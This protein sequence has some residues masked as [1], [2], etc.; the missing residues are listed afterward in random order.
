LQTSGLLALPDEIL[1][2]IFRH[3]CLFS[4]TPS[5]QLPLLGICHKLAPIVVDNMQ[6]RIEIR[7]GA[8][9]TALCYRLLRDPAFAA[10]VSHLSVHIDYEPDTT[11]R[12]LTQRVWNHMRR[13]GLRCFLRISGQHTV[14]AVWPALITTLHLCRNIESLVLDPTALIRDVGEGLRFDTIALQHALASLSRLRSFDMDG[15]WIPGPV[16]LES[17]QHSRDSLHAVTLRNIPDDLEEGWSPATAG[18]LAGVEH[19]RFACQAWSERTLRMF[20][21]APHQLQSLAIVI[22]ADTSVVSLSTWQSILTSV[23]PRLKLLT[24]DIWTEVREHEAGVDTL[25]DNDAIRFDALEVL[26]MPA[27]LAGGLHMLKGLPASLTELEFQPSRSF[28]VRRCISGELAALI[29]AISW[30]ISAAAFPIAGR[31]SPT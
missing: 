12:E 15:A 25:L 18:F 8:K 10:R 30:R 16:F 26:R 31:L 9:L 7:G 28:P 24:L 1:R 14:D 29:K 20:L 19:L 27:L 13:D 23:A 2:D 22:L 6:T 11:T 17:L 3:V 5:L 4:R 21:E